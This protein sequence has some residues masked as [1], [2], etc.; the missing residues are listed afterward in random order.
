LEPCH[1][2]AGIEFSGLNYCCVNRVGAGGEG[3][4]PQLLI[5]S[6]KAVPWWIITPS[7]CFWAMLS[8]NVVEPPSLERVNVHDFHFRNL[9]ML[10]AFGQSNCASNVRTGMGLNASEWAEYVKT[11]MNFALF[12]IIPQRNVPAE[13]L[14]FGSKS[15]FTKRID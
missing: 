11:P 5:L 12:R 2:L 6:G 9:S 10:S 1:R 3:I 4:N 8:P 13:R 14:H 15:L 7:R